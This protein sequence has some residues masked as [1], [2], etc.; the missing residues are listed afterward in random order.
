M[1]AVLILKSK[2]P[3]SVHGTEVSC[4]CVAPGLLYSRLY[5][6]YCLYKVADQEVSMLLL[7]YFSSRSTALQLV[8]MEIRGDT[9]VSK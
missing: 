1:D 5:P 7:Q 6:L 2:N 8:Y 3:A 4:V 9:G